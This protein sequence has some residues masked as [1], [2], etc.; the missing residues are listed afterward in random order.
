MK[1]PSQNPNLG[2]V[3]VSGVGLPRDTVLAQ[4]GLFRHS[5]PQRLEQNLFKTVN[6]VGVPRLELG[7]YPLW[8]PFLVQRRLHPTVALDGI[9]AETASGMRYVLRKA[10]QSIGT[11]KIVASM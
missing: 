5:L 3:A 6:G 11:R 2:V 7:H 8:R 4:V 9:V 10:I 1:S